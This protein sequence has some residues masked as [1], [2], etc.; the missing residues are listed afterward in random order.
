[1]SQQQQPNA[2]QSLI[3]T[4]LFA[5]MIFMGL[6]LFMGGFGNKNA[7][8]LRK[9]EELLASMRDLNA[10]AMDVSIA[11]ENAL[12]QSRV[13]ALKVSKAE[14]DAMVLEGNVLVAD[15]ELK[16]AAL[17][18]PSEKPQSYA[19]VNRAYMNLQSLEGKYGKTEAWRRPVAVAALGQSLSTQVT[20]E[21]LYAQATA[22]LGA[23]VKTEMAWGLV[24][25]YE[26]IDFLVG[27]TGKVPNFSYAFAALLLAIVVRATVWHLAQKQMMWGRQMQQL[28]PYVR[29]L[30][31]KYKDKR[32]GKIANPTELQQE[33]MKLYSE[34]GIN[35]M[36]GCL[37]AFIQMPLFLLVYQCMVL[38]RF[39]F[40][41]GTFLWIHPGAGS[42]LG[43]PLATNLGERDYVLLV[44]YGIS[45]I[46]TTLLMPVS[47][48]SN[49]KQQR[50]MGLSM[51][52][53][54]TVVMFF[55]VLPSAFVLYWIFTNILSTAQSLRAY[56]LPIPPLQKVN[57]PHGAVFPVS[58]KTASSNGRAQASL[59][60]KTGA[61]K[62]R[63]K[64]R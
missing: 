60:G 9:P 6:Q 14:K 38:Y 18:A 46:S 39:G 44:I 28:Q 4:M 54:F 32:T 33:T 37:P 20:P 19:K 47:D 23:R 22:E 62:N 12:Y 31:D 13:N 43:I 63:K 41:A 15:A 3:Q 50:L 61:P 53:V 27:L 29:E 57:A 30:Q 10:R 42:F 64:R 8:D 17:R 59:V 56:R 55:W 36:S 40:Q 21:E 52:L 51:S 11:K 58:P 2:K 24:P 48:P 34:Y 25:G 35:P 49:V 1:M 5:A 26:F 7:G 45:M 16:S